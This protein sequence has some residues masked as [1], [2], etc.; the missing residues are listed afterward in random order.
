[1][2]RDPQLIPDAERLSRY[3]VPAGYRGVQQDIV[4]PG[5]YYLNPYVE[6]ITP[7]RDVRSHRVELSDIAFPSP[8]AS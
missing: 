3:V 5:T 8:T 7:S 4:P 1:M 2:G 6:T